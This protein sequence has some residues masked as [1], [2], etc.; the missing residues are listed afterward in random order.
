LGGKGWPT[1]YGILGEAAV[2]VPDLAGRT[3]WVFVC[4]LEWVCGG[5][6][7]C[8]EAGVRLGVFILK[9]FVG[10]SLLLEPED[11]AEPLNER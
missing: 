8:G 11:M 4:M 10:R 5:C 6:D 9:C 2:G 3:F 1:E 7:G